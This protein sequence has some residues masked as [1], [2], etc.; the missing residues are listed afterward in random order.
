MAEEGRSQKEDVVL[1]A[2]VRAHM[3][4]GESVDLLPFRHE[5]DV[6][7]PVKDFIGDWA[8]S[9]F[10]LHDNFF[11][12]WTRVRSVEVTYVEELTHEQSLR[13]IDEWHRDGYKEQAFWKTRRSAAKKDEEK[14]SK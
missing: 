2:H 12:P 5:E 3:V 6:R 13:Y 4:D 9:G 7:S 8:K 11:Y 1:V 14:N 10:L